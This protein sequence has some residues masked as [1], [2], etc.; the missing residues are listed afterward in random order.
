MSTTRH[1]P[2]L[3]V[4][5]LTIV[6]VSLLITTASASSGDRHPLYQKCLQNCI[7]TQ[8][9][10]SSPA[11]KLSPMLRLFRWTCNDDCSYQCTHQVT[12]A[13]LQHPD[14]HERVHH[15]YHGKWPFWRV[16]GMQEP[17]SVLFSLGNFWV[18]WNG[19][20]KVRRRV[21][22][23]L[24]VKRW[25]MALAVVQ[26]NTWFWSAVFH[27]RGEFPSSGRLCSI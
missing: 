1:R 21:N 11:K 17:A 20:R 3:V 25:M 15:Q 9:G 24:A 4:V 26:M 18:H 8:C 14:S 23:S 27:I 6:G 13:L 22:D 5:L 7:T 19:W 12:S 10:P 2:R 16:W